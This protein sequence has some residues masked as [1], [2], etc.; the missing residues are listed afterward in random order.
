MRR[1]FCL[2]AATTRKNGLATRAEPGQEGVAALLSG[3]KL[4][5][6][7]EGFTHAHQRL[8]KVEWELLSGAL[9]EE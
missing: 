7:P 4:A 5:I 9:G 6:Q 1:P 8:T 2:P 3:E